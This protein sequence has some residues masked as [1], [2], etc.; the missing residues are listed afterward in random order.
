LQHHYVSTINTVGFMSPVVEAMLRYCYLQTLDCSTPS[1]SVDRLIFQFQLILVSTLYGVMPLCE[2]AKNYGFEPPKD[3]EI[4]IAA[5]RKICNATSANAPEGAINHMV[6][7]V[8]QGSII[9]HLPAFMIRESFRSF[10]EER[11]DILSQLLPFILLPKDL[12]DAGATD[13]PTPRF[14]LVTTASEKLGEVLQDFG[15]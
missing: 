8:L 4:Y 14:Q 10:M 11:P 2:L 6:R 7:M 9:R 1:L 13:E 3:A 15:M 12:P 5:F